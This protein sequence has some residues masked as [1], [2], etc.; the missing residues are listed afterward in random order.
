MH[1]PD[2]QLRDRA[3]A[4]HVAADGVLERAR[5]ADEV[6]AVVLVEALVLDGDE[7]RR[8]VA[9]QRAER[10]ARARPRGRTR[11]SSTRRAR[12]PRSTA[13][14]GRSAT[15]RPPGVPPSAP[16]AAARARR[17]EQAEGEHD[18][19]R[20]ASHRG[21][22]RGRA[23]EAGSA[24]RACTSGAGHGSAWEGR[25]ERCK[26]H[27]AVRTAPT[28]RFRRE[29]RRVTVVTRV[30]AHCE[31]R[32]IPSRFRHGSPSADPRARPVQAREG[33]LR[34]EHGAHR[35]AARRVR[36]ARPAARRRAAAGDARSPATSSRAACASSRSRPARW[37][38]IST[39][40]TARPRAPAGQPAHALDVR[41]RLLRGVAEHAP[42]HGRLPDRRRCRTRSRRRAARPGD[43]RSADHPARAPQALPADVRAVRRG[44]L[45]GA[46]ATTCAR[47]TRRG[48]AP[49]CSCARTRGTR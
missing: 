31:R 3:R 15:P 8:H 37:R 9:R 6:D 2:E 18:G 23:I 38:A 32:R 35:R 33:R 42:Q 48:G 27:R 45:R 47:S 16:R 44:A 14:A 4:A 46:R 39:T 34:R 7:R 1:V 40:P 11:R 25:S 41:D 20:A 22:A 30:A 21:G 43:G 24:R 19:A 5:D 17:E 29:A 26:I 28:R 49:P 13:A 10:D 36:A 12:T